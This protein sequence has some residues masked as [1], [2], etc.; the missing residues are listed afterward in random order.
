MVN[1]LSVKIPTMVL[2]GAANVKSNSSSVIF[3]NGQEAI[4]PAKF[5]LK[6]IELIDLVNMSKIDEGGYCM[7][8][9]VNSELQAYM[10][11]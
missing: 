7:Y 9:N 2:I 3:P 10:E 8:V 11:G 6:K 1:A 4:G 5:A